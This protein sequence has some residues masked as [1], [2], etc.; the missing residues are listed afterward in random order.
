MRTW[1]LT[2]S[3]STPQK[4]KMKPWQS[5]ELIRSSSVGALPYPLAY[6]WSFT[7]RLLTDGLWVS[8]AVA[9]TVINSSGWGVN[10]GD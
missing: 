3:T 10:S 7:S 8:L 6:A 5:E 4:S 1:A 9:L 2:R